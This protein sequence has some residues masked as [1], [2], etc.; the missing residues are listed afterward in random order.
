MP[1]TDAT[2]VWLHGITH[3]STCPADLTMGPLAPHCRRGL[4]FT[5]RFQETILSI[6]PSACF[7]VLGLWQSRSLRRKVD[8][9][10]G[11]RLLR[12]AKLVCAH[13]HTI[14]PSS[15]RLLTRWRRLPSRLWESQRWLC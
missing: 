1:A 3:G 10:A 13:L 9:H 14:I 5:L 4:D 8:A 2:T 11:A 12:L 7:V 6:L 15:L